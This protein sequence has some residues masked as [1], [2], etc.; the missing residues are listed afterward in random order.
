MRKA[1]STWHMTA[2]RVGHEYSWGV[3]TTAGLPA[4]LKGWGVSE[5]DAAAIVAE[6][7]KAAPAGGKGVL[8]HAALVV[9]ADNGD[10]ITIKRHA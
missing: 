4:A 1:I 3:F 6:A 8:R 2:G 5:G 7:E 10:P 9:Y